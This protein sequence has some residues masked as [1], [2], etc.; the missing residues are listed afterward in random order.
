MAYCTVSIGS[1]VAESIYGKS[2]FPIKSYIEH[3]GEGFEKQSVLKKLF[4]MDSSTHFAE[5]Y[6]GDTAMDDFEPVGEGGAYPQ[7]G[8]EEGYPKIISAMTWKSKFSVTQEMVEDVTL[9]PM[10]KKANGLITAY[11]RTREQFGRVL[12]AGGLV[13][14]TVKIGAK[15]FDCSAADGKA[16][17]AK[18]HPNKIKKNAQSNLYAGDFTADNLAT[19]ETI[20]QNRTGDNG[21]L[22][23]VTPDTILIPND[24]MLKNKVFS[25][26]GA[27]KDPATSNNAYNYHYGRW[28]VVVDPYLTRALAKLGITDTPWMLLDSQFN[29]TNDGA[30]FIDRVKLAVKSVIDENSDDNVWKGRGRFSGGFV[31]WR[32][33]LAG[34]MTG[35]TAF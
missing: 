5:K 8:F 21:E 14:T 25:V 16:L 27:D 7:N 6:S 18:D 30:V 17:F 33:A 28:N 10:R 4:R 34:G 2:Q 13:G 35:G 32:F 9:M 24:G 19:A 1:G 11:N 20:M 31:D 26:I 23:S 29:E 3:K 22:L 12:Y 15:G